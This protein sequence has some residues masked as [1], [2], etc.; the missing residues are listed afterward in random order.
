MRIAFVALLFPLAL[1]A[2]DEELSLL[3]GR[4]SNEC[5]TRKKPYRDQGDL[6]IRFNKFNM[7]DGSDLNLNWRDFPLTD[8]MCST[9]QRHSDGYSVISRNDHEV[10]NAC[11]E[12]YVALLGGPPRMPSK[13]PNSDYWEDLRIVAQAQIDRKKGK[14]PPKNVLTL[15]KLWENFTI[16]D[17]GEAVHGEYPMTHQNVM[18]KSFL[19][20]GGTAG[21]ELDYNCLPFRANKDFIG[22]TVRLAALN[23]WSIDCV[24]PINFLTKWSYG[25]PR[26]EVINSIA[27]ASIMG[28]ITLFTLC[29]FRKLLGRFGPM[30]SRKR[31][32]QIQ[33]LSI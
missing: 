19:T 2:A 27:V 31:M 4:Q 11:V 8:N 23:T 16:A 9:L 22:L 26:P 21:I 32:E 13:N 1:V 10:R 25:R 12:K 18:I 20:E 28:M 17:V 14:F 6:G 29:T 33:K 15:P 24:A 7:L 5:P 30:K 3:P